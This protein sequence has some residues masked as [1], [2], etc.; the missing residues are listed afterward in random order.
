MRL[1]HLLSGVPDIKGTVNRQKGRQTKRNKKRQAISLKPCP[2]ILL[3]ESIY[4]NKGIQARSQNRFE[5]GCSAHMPQCMNRSLTY[6][7]RQTS[8]VNYA[9]SIINRLNSGLFHIS[10]SRAKVKKGVWRMPRLSQ[11]MKDVISCDKPRLGAN[12]P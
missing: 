4:R 6:W 1:E 10:M 8:K 3:Y 11:A 9:E 5:T 2:A 12:I 7:T